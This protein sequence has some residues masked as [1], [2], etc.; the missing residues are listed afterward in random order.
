MPNYILYQA[1]TPDAV[2]ECR[3]SLLKYLLIYNLKPP[4]NIG[5]TVHTN[6]Q[7]SFDSFIPFFERFELAEYTEANLQKI[8]LI[9][10]F[11]S[12]KTSNVLVMNPDTYVTGPLDTVFQRLQKADF[13]FLK[14]KIFTDKDQILQLQKIKKYIDGNEV[15]VSDEKV[16]VSRIQNYYSTEVIGV[17][18]NSIPV[19]QNVFHLYLRLLPEIPAPIA[20]SFAF[21]YHA[22]EHT[23]TTNDIIKSYSCFPAFKKL[24]QLFFEKNEEESIPNLVKM[25]HHLDAETIMEE[26]NEYNRQPFVKK[27][28]SALAGKAWSIRQYQNK[29]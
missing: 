11:F 6:S 28:L 24:L 22:R 2:N 20:E 4:S 19:F 3:Y 9:K 23:V 26:K 13:L 10:N 25:V 1:L 14:E 5:I 7:A 29:F 15:K 27:L 8:D 18:N 21:A 12:T 16:D 17:N